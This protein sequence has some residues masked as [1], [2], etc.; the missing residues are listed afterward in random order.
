MHS[1]KPWSTG[2]EAGHPVPDAGLLIDVLEML[3]SAELIRKI[4]CPYVRDS[5]AI[6]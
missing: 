3:T 1:K 5:A 2:A 6:L 4:K